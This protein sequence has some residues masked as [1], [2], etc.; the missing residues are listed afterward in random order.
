MLTVK[1]YRKYKSY[2][3]TAVKMTATNQLNLSAVNVQI[4]YTKLSK[5]KGNEIL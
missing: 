5:M 4:G 3:D 2:V 1:R